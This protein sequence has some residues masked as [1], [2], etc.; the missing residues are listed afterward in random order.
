M[1]AGLGTRM[2]PFTESAPKAFL[3]VVG[4]PVAQF[5][6][7][8]LAAAGVRRIVV[9]V[10]HHPERMRSGL[11]A[12]D[13]GGAGLLVSDESRGLLGS[14]GGPR[15]ALPLLGGRFLYVNAEPLCSVDLG[16]LVRHH[17]WLRERHGVK[18]TL[19][20]FPEGPAGEKFNELTVDPATSLIVKRGEP[21]ERRPYFAG[22]AVIEPEAVAR[23]ADGVASELVPEVLLP[24]IREG[25]A[26][27]YAGGG[28][29]YDIGSPAQ[30]LGAQL[31]LLEAL[32]TGRLPG[33]WRRR[34][35]AAARRVAPG[36]WVARAASRRIRTVDW[37]GPC[38]YGGGGEPPRVLG[39]RAVLYGPAGQRELRDGIGFA[40]EWVSTG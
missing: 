27:A 40:G 17:A 38:F 12:L 26:G 11:A 33:A 10:H 15:H 25:K 19:T 28:A 23:L 2:R 13:P 5:A 4:V 6:I 18:L 34:I 22:F 14:A 37:E 29:T 1:A 9:N 20:V 39:P 35:E 7:D 32:E 36:I 31:A 21:A 24:A 16:A 8:A 30:W 3:P